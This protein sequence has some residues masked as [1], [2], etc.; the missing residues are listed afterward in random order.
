MAAQGD[1][2]RK[3]EVY[4]ESQKFRR[5]VTDGG[6]YSE[7]EMAVKVSEGGL[8]FS[9]Q[10]GGCLSRMNCHVW[11]RTS[12][13]TMAAT[14]LYIDPRKRIAGIVAVADANPSLKRCLGL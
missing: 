13:A 10:L 6:F 5:Q 12:I 4:K 11:G 3:V 9:A 8:G 14:S 7:R 2:V 1:F